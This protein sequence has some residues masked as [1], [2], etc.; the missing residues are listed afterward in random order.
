LRSIREE[1]SWWGGKAYYDFVI[2]RFTLTGSLS[3]NFGSHGKAVIDFG[4]G[5]D[6]LYDLKIEEDG[7]ILAV[8]CSDGK[9]AVASLWPDGRLVE[10]FGEGGKAVG[11]SAG[12]CHS[13]MLYNPEASAIAF[14]PDGMILTLQLIGGNKYILARYRGTSTRLPQEMEMAPPSS[15]EE[16][17]PLPPQVLMPPGEADVEDEEEERPPVRA[18]PRQIAPSS[19]QT[20]PSS[21]EQVE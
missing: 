20:A 8:G 17:G 7:K 19:E 14:Q 15:D 16:E 12:S 3:E 4:G 21:E 6:A 2:A 13:E 11:S 10:T 5:D 1:G 18:V 9:F